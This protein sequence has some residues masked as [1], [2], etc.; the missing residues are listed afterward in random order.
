LP[1]REA[2]GECRAPGYSGIDSD[3][4]GASRLLVAENLTVL[5]M[6]HAVRIFRDV[7]LV[8]YQDNRVALV[9]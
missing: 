4:S 8:R 9:V 5:D 2:P 6:D 7:V 1:Q 3:P